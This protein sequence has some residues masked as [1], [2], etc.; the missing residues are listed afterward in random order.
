[1]IELDK[2]SEITELNFEGDNPHIAI[3]HKSQN[4]SA[5]LR[6]DALL[7][8]SGGTV[9]TELIKSLDGVVP[10][11]LLVKM[12][13]ENKRRMLEEKLVERIRS[14][15][16]GNGDYVYLWVNDFSDDMV[17]FSYQEQLFAVD[18]TE[19]DGV[20]EVGEEPKPASR[21]DLYVD[22]N[23]GEELIKAADWLKKHPIEEVSDVGES[24]E[25][26]DIAYEEGETLVPN[27]KTETEETMTVETKQEEVIIKSQ[28]ELADIIKAAIEADRVEQEAQRKHAELVKSTTEVFKSMDFVPEDQMETLVKAVLTTD[29]GSVVLAVLEK[30][31]ESIVKAKEEAAAQIEEIKKEFG[32]SEAIDEEVKDV[33]EKS[34]K[35]VEAF[36]AK[37]AK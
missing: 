12:S 30:A 15:M 3:C 22:S 33:I 9:T 23:T 5:N 2:Y 27:N 28:A 29:E 25:Q 37:Y 6:H 1:M 17:V 31:Q 14:N 35:G 19:V 18:Y 24:G 36:V 11:Q 32:K 10:E 34:A 7:L 21:K 13:S 26:G 16:S 8:K 4:Y 20:I